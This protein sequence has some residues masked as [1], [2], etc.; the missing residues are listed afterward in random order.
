MKS[1]VTQLAPRGSA[2]IFDGPC[3]ALHSVVD[4]PVRSDGG[5]LLAAALEESGLSLHARMIMLGYRNLS[6]VTD[7]LFGVVTV[8]KSWTSGSRNMV[9]LR[10]GPT[11]DGSRRSISTNGNWSP[12]RR[13]RGCG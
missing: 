13:L 2:A 9:D 6:S 7:A 1:T 8:M 12:R 10:H 5:A 11:Q 4:L 3:L